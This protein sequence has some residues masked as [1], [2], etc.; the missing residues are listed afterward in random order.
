M[1][2]RKRKSVR[3]IGII[4][5][6]AR[7]DIKR[8]FAESAALDKRFFSAYHRRRIV[9]CKDKRGRGAR[10]LRLYRKRHLS[11]GKY[12]VSAENLRSARSYFKIII[13]KRQSVSP[14][15]KKVICSVHG[16]IEKRLSGAA[17]E[18]ELYSRFARRRDDYP[19][20]RVRRNVFKALAASVK[21]EPLVEP[22]IEMHT[23]L[24]HAHLRQVICAAG[25]KLFY[26]I[27]AENAV[28]PRFHHPCVALAG[29]SAVVEARHIRRI[30]AQAQSLALTRLKQA[31]FGKGAKL[32]SRFIDGACRRGRIKHHRL[33]ARSLSDIAHI[34]LGAYFRVGRRKR[35]RLGGKLRIRKT[36]AERI[37]HTL[38]GRSEA[39]IISVADENILFILLY[40]TSA[41]AEILCRRAFFI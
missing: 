37:E 16:N 18:I 31:R 12:G 32:I 24:Y 35:Q 30:K 1:H 33:L 23:S 5:E 6:G 22:R 20:C 40:N 29:L 27:S 15:K 13:R 7:H 36:E 19:V 14:F 10:P 11:C 2:P 25:L 8:T 4:G 38:P 17:R 3:H 9:F 39:L 26:I 34:Y 41:R 21:S 28:P